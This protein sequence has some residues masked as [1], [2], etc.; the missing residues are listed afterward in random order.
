MKDGMVC[1]C[2]GFEEAPRVRLVSEKQSAGAL[3]QS[4]MA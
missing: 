3:Q 4:E 2:G 1:G